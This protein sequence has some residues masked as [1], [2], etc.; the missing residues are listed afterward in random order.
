MKT[1]SLN[2]QLQV[3]KLSEDCRRQIA[4]ALKQR[5]AYEARAK[6][7]CNNEDFQSTMRLL[8]NEFADPRKEVENTL[9][10]DESVYLEEL[11]SHHKRQ[12]ELTKS[13]L[14]SPK[15]DKLLLGE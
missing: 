13:L 9:A 2:T 1:Y 8:E 6:A 10:E 4:L 12:E 14:Y 15:K 11:K 5:E 7:V 3:Q